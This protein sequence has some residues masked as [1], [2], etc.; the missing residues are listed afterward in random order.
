M[1]IGSLLLLKLNYLLDEGRPICERCSKAKY[2]CAG[3][4]KP[5]EFRHAKFDSSTTSDRA[6]AS[7]PPS[8]RPSNVIINNPKV[9]S[10]PNELSLVAFKEDISLSF[11]MTNFV[12]RTYATPW[13]QMATKGDLGRLPL[14]ASLALSHTNFGT[15]YNQQQIK[16]DGLIRYSHVLKA[17]TPY[18]SDPQK[19]GVENLIIPVL[20]LLIHAVSFHMLINT[21]LWS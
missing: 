5:L 4:D 1:I 12:W 19:P 18:L 16:V 3:Y 10:L 9:V 13:I 2:T 15:S 7:E 8:S 21:T 6:P 14:D 20:M 11:L 17:L